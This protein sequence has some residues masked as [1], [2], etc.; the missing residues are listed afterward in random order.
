M[1]MNKMKKYCFTILSL[2]LSILAVAQPTNDDCSGLIDLGQAPFS[3]YAEVYHNVGATPSDIGANNTPS[4]FPAMPQRD[5]WFTFIASDTITEYNIRVIGFSNPD[6]G[7]P[8]IYNPEF[9]L[10]RGPECGENNLFEFACASSHQQGNPAQVGIDTITLSPG[11]RYYV[12][13]N[14]WGSES[15]Q[16]GGFKLFVSGLLK[17]LTIAEE[18]STDECFGTIY[19]SGGPVGK[20]KNDEDYTYTI[21]PKEDPGCIEFNLEYYSLEITKVVEGLLDQLLFYDGKDTEAPLIGRLGKEDMRAT[22]EGV[23]NGGGVNYTVK[24]SSGCLTVRFT[25]NSELVFPGFKGTWRCLPEDCTIEE[26]ITI[27][28]DITNEEIIENVARPGMDVKVD[29]INCSSLSYGVFESVSKELGLTNGIILSTGE[30]A[31]AIGPN[32]GID[33]KSQGIG[34]MGD[35]DLESTVPGDT[36]ILAGDTII[37]STE[38]VDACA[39]IVDVYTPTDE[40]SFDYTVGSEEYPEFVG[41][42]FNDV[43][44]FLI[45]GE[46][47]EG[48][49]AI[50][51]QENIALLPNTN[52]ITSINSVNMEANWEHYRSNEFFDSG[53][54]SGSSL[55]YDGFMVDKYSKKGYLTATKKV[56]PCK[57]YKLKFS[58]A[59]VGDDK[60]D[61]G[62]FISRISAGGPSLGIDFSTGLEQFIES[63]TPETEYIELT[64]PGYVRDTVS[65]DITVA[66]TAT[67]DVDYTTGIPSQVTFLPGETTK[68]FPIA[69]LADNIPEGDETVEISLSKEYDCGTY[70][71]EPLVINI[72]D[73]IAVDIS[74]QQDT[75]NYCEGTEVALSASGGDHYRWLPADLFENNL[76]NPQRA[77]PKGDTWVTV[78]GRTGIC[79]SKDSVFLKEKAFDLNIT[80]ETIVCPGSEVSL[81]A[82][83]SASDVTYEWSDSNGNVVGQGATYTTI[84]TAEVTYTLTATPSEGCEPKSSTVQVAV[85]PD[86]ELSEILFL[87]TENNALDP[88]AVLGEGQIKLSTESVVAGA[89]YKWYVNEDLKSTTSTPTSDVID[90]STYAGMDILTFKV[91]VVD[92]N[93]CIKREESSVSI[94]NDVKVVIPNIFSPDGDNSNDRFRLVNKGS[95]DIDIISFKVYNR[96]G[97][98][99]YDN[100]NGAEGWDGTYNGKKSPADTYVYKVSYRS[101]VNLEVVSKVGE[102]T[103][104]R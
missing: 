6:Q 96:W 66:G 75:I 31:N 27:K 38:T 58:I 28:T 68:R 26:P 21:C 80:G 91:E 57:K 12:R 63:C 10:Y 97:N 102:V 71:Y 45:S 54:G 36:I 43:Y 83:S 22:G 94:Q 42:G 33:D 82:A 101:K 14:D 85:H 90:V 61:S 30:A 93:G 13:V 59:D 100:E 67:R 1:Y 16:P 29:T 89:N 44:A 17:P 81:T 99:V 87:D 78:E 51:N 98:L 34:T 95:T 15:I 18:G 104:L 39:L 3:D 73:V 72:Q 56:L 74:S 32:N 8:S 40:I 77:K 4:C 70:E 23:V 92:T 65:Y 60:F 25:S 9:A 24:S 53:K 50:N 35:P 103:L 76:L 49:P 55:E 79:V 7:I 2:C 88:E 20:Y 19:D 37:I 11:S 52:I 84:P 47:I 86:F 62:V 5:V 69:V 41:T 48:D 46:G 64:I